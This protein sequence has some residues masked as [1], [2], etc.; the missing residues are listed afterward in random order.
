MT[1]TTHYST[2]EITTRLCSFLSE[3]ILAEGLEINSNTELSSIGVD[4]FSLMEV[5][6]FIERSLG[7]V[8]P[9]ESLTPE[10]I[11]SVDSLSQCCSVLLSQ[12]NG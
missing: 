8:L 7:V 9:A 3:N 5:V 2:E 10:N 11:A 1:N 4:S 6:L 12:T